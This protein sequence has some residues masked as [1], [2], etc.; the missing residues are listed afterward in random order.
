MSALPTSRQ[1]RPRFQITDEEATAF[2]AEDGTDDDTFGLQVYETRWAAYYE[3]LIDTGYQLRPRFRPGWVRSWRGTNHYPEDCEDSW[4]RVS[5]NTLDAVRVSDGKQVMIKMILPSAEYPVGDDQSEVKILQY[6]SSP[7]LRSDTRN[8][9]VPYLDSFPIPGVSGGIFL[10]TPLLVPW[11][12]PLLTTVNEAVDFMRQIFEVRE[13]VL[14]KSGL[15]INQ[16]GLAFLHEHR[17]AHRSVVQPSFIPP[18]PTRSFRDCTPPN[19]M[20]NWSP[21]IDEPF[22][23]VRNE[24]SL[25]GEYYIRVGI[26]TET[27]IRY[28]FIDFDLAT[29]FKPGVRHPRVTGQAGRE[30]SVPELNSLKRYNPYKVDIFMI[31]A[32]LER[33]LVEKFPDLAFLRPLIHRMMSPRPR[34]RPTA[35]KVVRM[36]QKIIQKRPTQN[37]NKCLTPSPPPGVLDSALVA[38]RNVL[39]QGFLMVLGLFR[40]ML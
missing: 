29:Y 20:M 11:N 36:F 15:L 23:P 4:S 8:H 2:A 10:V 1:K 14:S 24:C 31:G 26:R 3:Y 5:N 38:L 28:Y 13:V 33:D 18:K 7:E 19:I 35:A 30:R 6:L 9:A 34:N 21:L 17:V 39:G 25:D 22:H 12:K 32:F 40:R 16:Q 27:P 37:L